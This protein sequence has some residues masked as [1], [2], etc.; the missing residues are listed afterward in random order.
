MTSLFISYSS[1]DRMLAST[2]ADTLRRRG[3][4]S[5]FVDFDADRGI[6]PGVRWEDELYARLRRADGVVFLGTA[7]S[8]RSKWCF[9]E[10]AMARSMGKIIVPLAVAGSTLPALLDDTQRTEWEVNLDSHSDTIDPEGLEHLWA[11]LERLGLT[12]WD[13]FAWDPRR[14][15]FPG[16]AA[17]GE[18]DAAAFFGREQETRELLER[19][20]RPVADLSARLIAV[21]GAS[22]SGKSSLV[23]AGVM[24]RLRRMHERWVVVPSFAP[25]EAPEELLSRRLASALTAAG[26]PRDW[27]E[28]RRALA[29][30]G[31]ALTEL[32]RDLT[33]AADAHDARVL[34][35]V[36]QAEELLTRTAEDERRE[37]LRLLVAALAP[38]SPL[39]VVATL[40]GEFLGPLLEQPELAEMLREPYALAPLSPAGMAEAI[41]GPARLG[42]LEFEDDLVDRMV[43]ETGGGEALPLLAFA[44]SK[45]HDAARTAGAR[46][47]TEADYAAIGGVVGAL[48]TTANAV[49][50]DVSASANGDA[51][52]E[53]LLQLVEIRPDAEPT[54]RR[55]KRSTFATDAEDEIV[56]AFIQARLLSSDKD[57]GEPVV[58]VTHE[59]LL[60]D[61]PP[62]RAAIA[63]RRSELG[64]DRL[65][66]QAREWARRDH[67]PAF[68]LRGTDLMEGEERIA[69]AEEQRPASRLARDFVLASR[70]ARRRRSRLVLAATATALFVSIM[71]AVVALVQRNEALRFRELLE[72]CEGETAIASSVQ[73]NRTLT[74]RPGLARARDVPP[75]CTKSRRSR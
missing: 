15:P 13:S 21:I 25:A 68:L 27:K 73:Q 41:R 19:L 48:R 10:L 58:A 62:L 51:V 31:P 35:V 50:D 6:P 71:L 8:A 33:D 49:A 57:N 46:R 7:S 24:P 22:G 23:R 42:D 32:A 61:W 5:L 52:I 11:A 4:E 55:V 53:T 69:T 38:G 14:S 59:A 65:E 75:V 72:R 9:A 12:A 40:R 1:D 37:F 54:R 60:H 43:R 39:V 20:E 36:D 64:G 44:L 67:D 16:L 18:R 63:T 29:G 28:V 74:S 47:V 66:L 34:L 26:A 17:F 3:Y 45:L 2:L 30:G 70:R 56:D